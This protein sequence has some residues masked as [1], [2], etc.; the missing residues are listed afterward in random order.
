MHPHRGN[1]LPSGMLASTKGRWTLVT[2]PRWQ[3]R[4]SRA[5]AGVG[6]MLSRH[7]VHH[8][9]PHDS[10]QC[11]LSGSGRGISPC[12]VN[13][14][15]SFAMH[16]H[17]EHFGWWLIFSF[18]LFFVRSKRPAF[19]GLSFMFLFR[20]NVAPRKNKKSKKQKQNHNK[21]K[22]EK[23]KRKEKK[24]KRKKKEKEKKKK[25]KKEKKKERKE[26]NAVQLY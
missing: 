12:A 18:F 1:R 7:G 19:F 8:I 23:K 14:S 4:Q 11:M 16:E 20:S 13:M 10:Q 2:R 26:K 6:S 5:A 9:T 15:G 3:W 21:R 17:T 25:R 22:K 24:K